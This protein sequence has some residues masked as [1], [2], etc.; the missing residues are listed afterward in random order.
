MNNQKKP[1]AAATAK[2]VPKSNAQTQDKQ[3]RNYKPKGFNFPFYKTME[4]AEADNLL[5][6]ESLINLVKSPSVGPKNKSAALTPYLAKHKRKQDAM[7]AFFH[8][9]VVDHDDDDL[10]KEQLQAKYDPFNVNYVAYTTSSH[11]H[12]KK[13]VVGNRW[14]VIIPL[15]ELVTQV[16]FSKFSL[17]ITLLMKADIAQARMQQVF[18]A[19]N[20]LSEQAPYDYILQLDKELFDTKDPTSK[21]IREATEYFDER[22]RQIEAEATKAAV[23]KR[24]ENTPNNSI[25]QLVNDAYDIEEVIIE[26]GYKKQGKKYLSPYSNSGMAGVIILE[27]KLYS[28]HGESDPLSSL[29]HDGHALDAFDVLCHLNHSGSVSEAVRH[30]AN[31]LDQDGQ[32]QRQKEYAEANAQTKAPSEPTILKGGVTPLPFNFKSFALNG[33]STEMRQQ[34]LEDKYVLNGIAILGQATALYAKPNSGKTLLTIHLVCEGIK[35]GELDPYDVFYVNA[36]DNFKGLVTKLEIAEKYGFNMVAP[37]YKEFSV[38]EFAEYMIAMVKSDQCRG[39][40]II[41]DTLKKFTNIMDKKA[42]SDF[43]KVMRGFVSKGGTMILLAHT[44][45]NRDNDGKVVYSGTSDIVDDVDCAYTI[46]ISEGS[47]GLYTTVVFENIKSRGD[48]QQNIVFK[49]YNKV[50][51]EDGGYLALLDSVSKVSDEQA[52][53]A[54]NQIIIQEMLNKNANIIEAIREAL[55]SGEMSK[56]DLIK[57]AQQLSGASKDRVTKIL[58]AHTGKD[59]SKGHRWDQRKGEKHSYFYRLITDDSRAD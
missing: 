59:W 9:I 25:I 44:N 41:L 50:T 51:I 5:N 45:K 42:S 1:L 58:S 31:E 54:K 11:Q 30:Y 48:V 39:K 26:L 34:M 37:G 17:G 6:L 2:G 52:L 40:V 21:L 4:D 32:K 36:D 24:P 53:L 19:P 18:Y 23:K 56:T 16:E 22:N 12:D 13:G 28:H 3:P 8:A 46:D 14:K 38:N 20:R 47:D 35:S 27:D 43:G 10:T 29:N 49:Y 55:E 15:A 7:N 57:T 33:N